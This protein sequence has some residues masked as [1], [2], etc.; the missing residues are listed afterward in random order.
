M[1]KAM[2][3][4]FHRPGDNENFFSEEGFNNLTKLLKEKTGINIVLTDKNKTLV[5]SRI[6]KLLRKHQLADYNAYYTF[7]QKQGAHELSEFIMALTTNTTEFFREDQHFKFIDN[8]FKKQSEALQHIYRRGEL[9]VWCSASSTGQEIY[10]T[11]ITLLNTGLFSPDK[12]RIK[13]LS[14]DI[15]TQA[16]QTAAT[17]IYSESLIKGIPKYFLSNYFN[18]HKKPSGSEYEV[19][20]TLANLVTFAPLNLLADTYPLKYPFDLILCRN[21][22][23][24][25]DDKDVK[26][27]VHKMIQH[28][29]PGGLFFVGHSESGLISHPQLEKLTFGVFRKV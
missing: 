4:Q 6:S 28:L 20:D 3:F 7:L 22:L 13:A 14:T 19:N 25:F 5:S 1:N 21:V 27:S 12:V 26:G 16:L 29:R 10:S 18:R 9:R 2:K 8:Y 17:G 11:L 23:I 15:D 24:Y